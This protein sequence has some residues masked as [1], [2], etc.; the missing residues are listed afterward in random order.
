[1]R[2]RIDRAL[3][4]LGLLGL[5]AL[6]GACSKSPSAPTDPGINITVD[7]QALS[8]QL[9]AIKR[10]L[11]LVSGADTQAQQF[12]VVPAISTGTL[13]FRYLPKATSGGT[14]SGAARRD[15]SR[16]RRAAPPR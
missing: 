6:G 12:T 13:T 14:S 4:R 15:R 16:W 10:G 1:M 11:L 3:A 5:L 7:A 2:T 8:S 9:G